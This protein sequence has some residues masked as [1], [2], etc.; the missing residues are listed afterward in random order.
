[1]NLRCWREWRAVNVISRHQPRMPHFIKSFH[2]FC[3]L[4][5]WPVILFLCKMC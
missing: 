5:F 2:N 3:M 4:I 1:M